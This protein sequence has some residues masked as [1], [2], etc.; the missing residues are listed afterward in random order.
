MG[1]NGTVTCWNCDTEY[2]YDDGHTNVECPNCGNESD[3]D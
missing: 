1:N 3:V 2:G